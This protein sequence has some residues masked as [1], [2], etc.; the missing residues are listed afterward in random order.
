MSRVRAL[1]LGENA[2]STVSL[3]TGHPV[4][5]ALSKPRCAAEPSGYSACKPLN[6]LSSS[7]EA[8]E[9]V[10]SYARS[11]RLILESRYQNVAMISGHA[12]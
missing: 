10:G 11:T 8:R 1:L 4:G 6:M 12:M 9:A 2:A 5:A 7:W 3:C